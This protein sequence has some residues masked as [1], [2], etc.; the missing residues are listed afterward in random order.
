MRAFFLPIS[1]MSQISETAT[2]KW[3]KGA[4]ELQ[5]I[6]KYGKKY[7]EKETEMTIFAGQVALNLFQGLI[8]NFRYYAEPES[9][10]I[11]VYI[12]QK[13]E[14]KLQFYKLH[15]LLR[16]QIWPILS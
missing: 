8:P 16:F 5:K 15:G 2:V 11:K 10:L 6:I 12:A 13:F 3:A 4:K 7:I 14:K 9:S 1:K